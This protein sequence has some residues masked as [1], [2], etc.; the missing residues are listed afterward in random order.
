MMWAAAPWWHWLGM[1]SFWAL[2]LL[3]AIWATGRVVPA[4]GGAQPSARSI[5]D[6]RLAR[7]EIDIG[8]YRRL[9]RE[10]TATGQDHRA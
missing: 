5:L 9:R 4:A 8:E 10:L 6:V 7:G 3:V 1:A 2:V